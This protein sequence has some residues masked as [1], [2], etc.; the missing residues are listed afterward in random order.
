MKVA[1]KQ[2]VVILLVS[3][4]AAVVANHLHPRRIP[5]VQD[6]SGQVE[7]TAAK[8][9]I[10][11]IPL[12]VALEKSRFGE[13]AFI[14]ART[15]DHFAK[16]H[17]AGAVSVPFEQFDEFFPAIVE[18]IDSGRELVMYC[19]NRECDDALLLSIELQALG[20]SNLLLY[21]DGFELWKKSGGPVEERTQSHPD[22]GSE[23]T[24]QRS[25]LHEGVG[26]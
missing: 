21:V 25:S 16:G 15:A 17:I 6:W 13:A 22:G 1:V 23:R 19:S 8:Q 4:V 24:T 12:A 26:Q 2:I 3:A 7:A 18:L 14:D 11:V 9:G 10:K 5:W 20:C